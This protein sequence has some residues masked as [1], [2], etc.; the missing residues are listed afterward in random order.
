MISQQQ[1]DAYARRILAEIS[2]S[3]VTELDLKVKDKG[4]RSYF[5]VGV[6]I[7]ANSAYFCFLRFVED[8][9][10]SNTHHPFSHNNATTLLLDGSTK[11]HR[12]HHFRSCPLTHHQISENLLALSKFYGLSVLYADNKLS[13][14]SPIHLP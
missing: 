3:H 1:A 4:L 9:T 11:L 7:R 12:I 14:P 10:P 13:S 8:Q 5:T 6:T 2:K